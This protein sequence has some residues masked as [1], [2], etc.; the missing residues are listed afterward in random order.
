ML[1]YNKL[2]YQGVYFISIG[3]FCLSILY[4]IFRI[5]ETT[6]PRAKHCSGNEL[7][8]RR[9]TGCNSLFDVIHV[10][11]AFTTCFRYRQNNGRYKVLILIFALCIIVFTYG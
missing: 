2:G 11:E 8:E 7:Q 10:K 4:I 1:V 6:G 5:E 9:S 3:L